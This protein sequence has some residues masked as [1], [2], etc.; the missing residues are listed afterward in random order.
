MKNVLIAHQSTIPH[1]RVPFYNTLERLRPETWQFQVVFDPSELK[2]K[3]FFEEGLDMN[4]FHFPILEV[5]TLSLKISSKKIT[6][7]SF[8]RASFD[9]DL[10]IIENAV[11]NLSYPI[12]HLNK[13]RGAHIAYWGIG[14]DMNVIKPSL[15]KIITEKIKIILARKADGFFAYSDGVKKY[16]VDRGITPTKI[17]VLDNTIDIMQQRSCFYRFNIE[18]T[19][20]KEQFGI[21]GCHVLLF[22]GRLT[23]DKKIDLLLKSFEIL[24]KKNPDFRLIVIGSGDQ[25]TFENCSDR[26]TYLGPI[27]D[28]AK[29]GPIYVA[30]DLFTFPSGV[31][32]GPLQAFC[33][34]LPLI[35]IRTPLSGPEVEYLNPLNSIVMPEDTTPEE[36]ADRINKLFYDRN[37]LSNLRNTT[38]DS[39]KHLTIDQMAM[40][41]IQGVNTI[42]GFD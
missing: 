37:E 26:V 32:L 15:P 41:F 39:I 28:L 14:R 31:G 17:F 7:Q 12:S 27:T 10:I 40:N 34:D 23:K 9:A 24:E 25:Y 6:Y 8:L 11:N 16:L 38:W 22:V 3:R 2:N 35:T 42:L 20:I 21:Q 29:L 13:L 36:F 33:Y 4:N 1:Y 5:K 30:S 18:R 19:R